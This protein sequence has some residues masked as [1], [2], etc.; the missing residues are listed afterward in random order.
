MKKLK[1]LLLAGAFGGML[2]GYAQQA[3]PYQNPLL[4]AEARAEDLLSRMTI[5]EKVAQIRHLHSWDVFDGQQLNK[6]KLEKKCSGISYGFFEGFP[7]TAA[8][9]QKTF[10]EIQTYLVENT[11][12]GI[13]ALPVAES[14]HGVV[15][16]GATI[17]PQNIALGSTFNPFLAYQK[18]K[19]ISGELNTMGVK[20]VL[21]PCIDVVRE[22]RWGRVEESFGEDPFLCSQMAVAEVKGYLDH[23]ISPMLKHYGPHG[24]PQGGLNLASVECGIRDLFDIYLK[25]FEAVCAQTGVLAVMSSYN[26]WNRTPNSASHFMLTEILR[27]KF[28]FRGYVYS[29]WGA[30]D[31]LKTF[32]HTASSNFDAARQAL[33]AGVDVEASSS[34]FPSLIEQIRKG[35]FDVKIVDRAVKRVLIA[36]FELGLFED[37]YLDKTTYRLALRAPESV[38]LSRRIA[39]ESIVLLKNQNQL[40]PLNPLELKS[41]AVIGPN[42]DYVQFGDYTWSKN[43]EDGVTPLQGI[44]QLLEGKV[45]VHYAKG[46]SLASMD[47]T[48]IAE[49]VE[50]VKKSD[51]ALVFVGSSSTAFVRHSAEP[52]TSGEGVDLNDISLT[53]AQE[54]LIKRVYATG[55][56]VVVVLVAGKPFAMPWV[57]E[58][59]PAIVAQWYGGEQEGHAIADVLFGRVNPS[60]KLSFSFPKST[61]HLPAYY[62]HLPTDKGF[63]KEPGTYEKPGRDYVFSDPTALWAFGHGLSYTS[64]A[65]SHAVTDKKQYQPFDTINVTVAVKNIGPVKGKEVVQVYVRDVVSSVVTPVKQLKG[66]SKIDVCP[67]QTIE[68][69]IKVPVTE[70]YLTDNFGQRMLEPGVFEI[71]VGTASDHIYHTLPVTVGVMDMQFR[72]SEVQTSK[73]Q[74]IISSKQLMIEGCVRDVQATPMAGC[75]VKCLRTGAATKTD[76][77][78]LY[79]IKVAGNDTLLFSKKGYTEKKVAVRQQTSINIQ[80]TKGF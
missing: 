29:D 6:D 58:H 9:C 65:Y 47:T 41:V 25:P 73:K 74:A 22:L 72:E 31:M 32:H 19:H 52:S 4:P 59:I 3:L 11:R 43:K 80:L 33:E 16:E 12:L 10:R 30:I 63:Y 1:C 77:K 62:N 48:G 61:G 71:Q 28:G 56:P 8:N 23:G 70:L 75:L 40:L 69:V 54:T 2:A 15:H 64:F 39:E 76:S 35:A 14:L 26:S 53:G 51:V 21:A 66:F 20:Q 57:K 55:K 79:K 67:G 18:T 24:N 27:N 50:A 7:L 17:Y 44:R 13:P 78:G 37:P 38:A 46:C 34:C 36:K 5:E 42:A 60:G 68:T 45:K 49:A